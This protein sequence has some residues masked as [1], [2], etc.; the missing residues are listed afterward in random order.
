MVLAA[1]LADTIFI[2]I[3]TSQK[4]FQ[5]NP[6]KHVD[7]GSR[8][9]GF[10]AHGDPIDIHGHSAALL[11]LA[12]ILKPGGT[13]Y[14]SMPF[15]VERIEYNAHRI[16]HLGAMRDLIEC[17]FEIIDF[18][19]VDDTGELHK[20]ANLNSAVQSSDHHQFALAIFE[21]RKLV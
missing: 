17:S 5:K 3:S 2:R 10:V 9:D 6:V 19:T 1:L 12:Q 16:F 20:N 18:A 21:L 7:F 8:I 11:N 15:G 4:I 14:L 13:L